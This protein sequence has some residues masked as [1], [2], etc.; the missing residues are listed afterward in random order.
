MKRR[1]T[2]VRAEAGPSWLSRH[3]TAIGAAVLLLMAVNLG[4]AVAW[5]G[6]SV[7]EMPGIGSGYRYLVYS[8][9]R[10][11]PE[12][13]P[14]SKLLAALPLAFLDLK[15]PDPPQGDAQIP[16]SDAFIH[17]ANRDRPIVAWARLPIVGLALL[18][19]AGI[20]R[21]AGALH[22]PAA[23]LTALVVA[24]FHPSL[25]AHGHLA[26]TDFVSAAAFFFASWAFRRWTRSPGWSSAAVVGLGIALAVNTRFTG[27]LLLPALAVAFGFS[28]PRPP[29]RE[30]LRLAAAGA[31]VILAA[32]WALYGF[33]YAPWPGTSGAQP[34]SPEL[35]LPGRVI[36]WMQN[37]R[38]LPEAYLEG[39][40][41]QIEHNRG[42]HWGYF[43]GRSVSDGSWSYYVVAFALKNT[44]GFLLLAGVALVGL[45]RKGRE[46]LA[47][48]VMHWIAPAA[49]VFLF[50]SSARIQLGERYILAVYPYLALLVAAIVPWLLAQRRG[51]FLL[52]AALALHVV[53]SLWTAPRGYLTYFNFA[54]GGPEG[55][56]RYLADSNIDWGQDLPRL[57]AWM[58]REKVEG[59]Q[60][61]YFGADDPDRYGIVHEDLP[62]WYPNRPQRPAGEPF[63]GTVAVST[64]LLLGF[65]FPAE[66]NPYAFLR[67]RPPDARVGVF[68]VY[69]L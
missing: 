2:T 51:M 61:G 22:G 3:E 33:H 59:I 56:H 63:R 8:D 46:A 11:M 6:M 16:W 30:L 27:W 17:D 34:I 57:A 49:A 52:G 21:T 69:R 14:L 26:A 35:G 39:L 65:L 25:L 29:L 5:D 53:P 64:N 10:L 20:W 66:S 13:P 50:A 47:G 32:T 43:L 4:L 28:R 42:G 7:D 58:R 12:H 55:G 68:F 45:G 1:R 48:G 24:A 41:F 31:A 60:L 15:V 23:G 40:R 54:A 38:L 67:S 18:L 9:Y 37:V 62:T 44:P 19:A 36:G